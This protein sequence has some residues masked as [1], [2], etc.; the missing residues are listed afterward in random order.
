VLRYY[1]IAVSSG[2]CV[3][4]TDR[5]AMTAY[6]AMGLRRTSQR[7]GGGV[8]IQPALSRISAEQ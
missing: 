3:L 2:Q 1:T 7:G 4:M 5:P 6:T 8:K